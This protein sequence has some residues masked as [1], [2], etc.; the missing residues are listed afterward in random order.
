MYIGIDDDHLVNE[1]QHNP[2]VT[3]GISGKESEGIRVGE[4]LVAKGPVDSSSRWKG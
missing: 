2:S 3:P 1:H 4:E